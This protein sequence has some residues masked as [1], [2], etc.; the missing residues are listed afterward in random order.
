M[1]ENNIKRYG[2]MF[3]VTSV[4]VKD[5]ANQVSEDLLIIQNSGLQAEIHYK[6]VAV[7]GGIVYTAIILGYK[8]LAGKII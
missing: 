1:S 4:D 5:F 8:I 7:D 6:P 2:R 3:T